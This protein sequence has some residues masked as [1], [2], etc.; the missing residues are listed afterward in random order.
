MSDDGKT[1]WAVDGLADTAPVYV[2]QRGED[3]AHCAAGSYLRVR[4]VP[5]AEVHAYY[6]ALA[7]LLKPPP[8]EPT[9]MHVDPLTDRRTPA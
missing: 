8:D 7:K 4:P 6:A 1:W 2:F 3:D 5:E 9:V